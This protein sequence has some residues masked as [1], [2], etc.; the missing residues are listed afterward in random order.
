MVRMAGPTASPG[1]AGA[2]KADMPRAVPLARWDADSAALQKN[3]VRFS[4]FLDGASLV[5]DNK[6]SFLLNN[7]KRTPVVR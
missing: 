3:G 5:I 1:G 2:L 4:G 7:E 6:T